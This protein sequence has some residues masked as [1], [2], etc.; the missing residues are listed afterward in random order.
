M[1][2]RVRGM[3]V[4]P[5]SSWKKLKRCP[6]AAQRVSA[7]DPL[8]GGDQHAARV[9]L[10]NGKIGDITVRSPEHVT[11]GFDVRFRHRRVSARFKYC[12]LGRR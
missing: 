8:S 6:R 2:S 9:H 5:S 4:G 1:S 11:V 3:S 12:V 10:E 7:D